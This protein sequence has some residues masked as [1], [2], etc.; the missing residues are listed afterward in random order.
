ML[1][2]GLRVVPVPAGAKRPSRGGFG[3]G[4]TYSSDP[5]D[6][7]RSDRIA[8][9]TGPCDAASGSAWLV[10]LDLDGALTRKGA[11]SA[12]SAQLP[13]TLATHKGKHL[14]YWV[15]A[16]AERDEIRQWNGVL[17]VR[18][19]WDGE[20][21]APDLDLK[22]DGGYA[23]EAEPGEFDLSAIVELPRKA[24]RA[25]LKTWRLRHAGP[26]EEPGT[27]DLPEVGPVDADTET[28]LIEAFAEEWPDAGAGRHDASKALGGALRR[29]G[30]DRRSTERI[31]VAVQ[32][33]VG[34]DQPLVRVRGTLDA[35]DRTHRGEPAFGLATL[36]E[37]CGGA[38]R[39]SSALAACARPSSALLTWLS[40]RAKAGHSWARAALAD[41][42]DPDVGDI[43]W[44]GAAELARDVPP[45]E[46]L[47]ERLGIPT[48]G[49]PNMFVARA[50]GGK[51]YSAQALALAVAS[52]GALFGDMP[53]RQGVVR[54]LD[55]DQGQRATQMRYQW[56]ARGAGVD[57]R[58]L[59]LAAAFF[60]L[61]S[62]TKGEAIDPA[63]AA[64]LQRGV[65]GADLCLIDSLASLG[66]ALDEN[67]SRFGLVMG[68]LT[69]IT[70]ET[71]VTWL[72]LHHAGK[73]ETSREGRGTSAIRDRAGCVW[74][75]ERGGRWTQDKISELASEP[76]QGFTT[77]I[78]VSNVERR[79]VISLA[80][81]QA[82]DPEAERAAVAAYID[83]KGGCGL[84]QVE[85]EAGLD[86]SRVKDV[87]RVMLDDRLLEKERGGQHLHLT[88]AGRALLDGD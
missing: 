4:S 69:R 81:V 5:S 29:A 41:A 88:A 82:L 50:G 14:W 36:R 11:S 57:L 1:E 46:W 19:E 30:V 37:L 85:L 53:C 51:T 72:V 48:A 77:Q 20:G 16:S 62:L 65:E 25:I 17:G 52:G 32:D 70:Q 47:C 22:W 56:L 64:R 3:R 83:S 75:L 15:R 28:E 45:V 67:D 21:K 2:Q 86:R 66:G 87:V 42:E 6:F 33:A 55:N 27:D 74:L 9:L 40:C 59:P 63:A 24:L 10:C 80:E 78:E 49:R 12:L 8:I 13:A 54:H 84:R 7:R 61:T 39:S 71:G 60:D 31:A 43:T 34:S 79:A 26:V 44:V 73:T 18:Q 68:E 76:C 35:W 23:I 38:E 58:E